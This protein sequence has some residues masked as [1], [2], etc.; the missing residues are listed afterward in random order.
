MM[1]TI[2]IKEKE[3]VVLGYET[4]CCV[5]SD[6]LHGVML[7]LDDSSNELYSVDI[8]EAKQPIEESLVN[9][10]NLIYA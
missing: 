2:Q 4:H 8:N 10:D 1:E 6:Y 9:V 7:L 3:Y 5:Y